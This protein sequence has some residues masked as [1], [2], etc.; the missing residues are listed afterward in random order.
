MTL[1]AAFEVLPQKLDALRTALKY[2]EVFVE[3][4]PHAHQYVDAMGEL[5]A[6]LWSRTDTAVTAAETAYSAVRL[7]VDIER[8]RGA[9]IECQAQYNVVQRRLVT[10]LASDRQLTELPRLGQRLGGEWKGWAVN[11]RPVLNQCLPPMYEAGQGLFLCWQE[12]SD[13]TSTPQVSVHTVT[14]GQAYLPPVGD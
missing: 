13:R 3:D 8:A 5:V 4:R 6:D 2:L 1:E 10:E 9:L 12:L 14:V 7:P 11:I